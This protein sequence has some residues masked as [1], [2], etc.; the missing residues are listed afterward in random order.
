MPFRKVL[1]LGKPHF[2]GD[3]VTTEPMMR[4]LLSRG[5]LV[6]MRALQPILDLYEG[7]HPNLERILGTKS[8]RLT[9]MF[10]E[11][12]ELRERKFD[13]AILTNRSFRS[14]LVAKLARI[15]IRSGHST[16]RRAFLLTHHV[17]YDEL[18]S[19]VEC[20][21]D[22]IRLV[23]LDAEFSLP[24][25]QVSDAEKQAVADEMSGIAFGVQPGARF[26]EKQYPIEKM[27]EAIR[28]IVSPNERILF[29]GGK[30]EWDDADKLAKSLPCQVWNVAGKTDIR[31]LMARLS[32]LKLM[33]G[34]DTGVMHIAAAVGVPTITLFGPKPSSKWGYSQAPHL[35]IQAPNNDLSQLDPV[36][37]AD[38]VKER[39]MTGGRV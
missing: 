21:L 16:D 12:K 23:G 4:A 8:S 5:D 20:N 37:L 29:V 28:Q 2:L 33:L 39:L 11:A 3:A 15:P 14:A 10:R 32:H 18:R 1:H 36:W 38:Q 30:D 34:N 24:R 13:L 17:P 26:A 25:L 27:G 22:L 9:A 6:S 35:P 31:G 19:E 7:Y